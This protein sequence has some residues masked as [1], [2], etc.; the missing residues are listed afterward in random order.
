VPKNARPT[1]INQTY[2]SHQVTKEGKKENMFPQLSRTYQR[3]KTHLEQ[4]SFELSDPAKNTD[5]VV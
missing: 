2:T 4:T 1:E 5:R 3:K